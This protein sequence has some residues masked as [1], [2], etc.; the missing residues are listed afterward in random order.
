MNCIA[1]SPYNGSDLKLLQIEDL[2]E[3]VT[4]LGKFGAF[5]IIRGC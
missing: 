2:F 4:G 1:N 5:C 3:D